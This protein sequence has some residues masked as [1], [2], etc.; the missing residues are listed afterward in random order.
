[1]KRE[2]RFS[3][4]ALVLLLALSIAACD[5]DDMEEAVGSRLELMASPAPVHLAVDDTGTSVLTLTVLDFN[6]LPQEGVLVTFELTGDGQLCLD[7]SPSTCTPPDTTISDTTVAGLVSATFSHSSVGMATITASTVDLSA[8]LIVDVLD[9]KPDTGNPSSTHSLTSG[10]PTITSCTDT[11][12]LDGILTDANF[13]PLSNAPISLS[14]SNASPATLFGTFSPAS[15]TT[16]GF[17]SYSAT[18]TIDPTECASNCVGVTCTLDI[19]AT[20]TDIWGIDT[21]N[22]SL[23]AVSTNIP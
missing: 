9:A 10:D 17:G 1:M 11:V 14:T 5:E 22:S 20:F 13:V 7:S 8:T 18:F 6:L 21:F 4:S 19:Q 12:N 2:N 23:V 3:P 15:I 16:N